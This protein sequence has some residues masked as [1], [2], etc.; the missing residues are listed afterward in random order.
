M[1]ENKKI[2]IPIV[3]FE[4]V[5]HP[6][7]GVAFSTFV[8]KGTITLIKSSLV[9][10]LSKVVHHDGHNAVEIPNERS[11]EMKQIA[12]RYLHNIKTLEVQFGEHS[13]LRV[14]GKLPEDLVSIER[15]DLDAKFKIFVK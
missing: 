6:L 12:V 2:K 7:G 8:E 3:G 13:I 11:F 15:E 5:N 14:L 1:F 10:Y 4:C 9:F